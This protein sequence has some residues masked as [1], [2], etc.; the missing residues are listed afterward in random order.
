MNKDI[1][2]TNFDE[3]AIEKKLLDLIKQINNAGFY[4]NVTQSPAGYDGGTSL[5]LND[6][7]KIEVKKIQ[8]QYVIG[9]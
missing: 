8:G 4:I 9:K 5:I 2:L 7:C 3:I 6:G 1:F